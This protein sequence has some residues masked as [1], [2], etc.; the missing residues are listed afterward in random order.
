MFLR[1]T[2]GVPSRVQ[3]GHT[4]LKGADL[5][6]LIDDK[7]FFKDIYN[8]LPQV[9]HPESLL[10]NIALPCHFNPILFL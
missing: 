5:I 4:L 7:E 9:I 1:E 2:L 10:S 3:L 6:S 8:R